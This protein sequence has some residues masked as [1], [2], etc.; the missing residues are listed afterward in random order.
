MFCEF[1]GRFEKC[2]LT[3]SSACVCATVRL[4]LS[5]RF[6]HESDV[7]YAISGVALW[8]VGEITAGFLVL[9]VPWIPKA[10][11]SIPFL[12]HWI[13]VR[14][15]QAS[16]KKSLPRWYKTE[17]PKASR[18]NQD[19]SILNDEMPIDL[20]VLENKSVDNIYGEGVIR[21]EH[22]IEQES[23]ERVPTSLVDS[24]AY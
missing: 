23:V 10:L 18:R 6:L 20:K 5:V 8:I 1:I 15:S 3:G 14:K 16:S 17:T 19:W 7:S 2:R 11:K 4:V 9:G 21:V 22:T 24:K 13:E 12:Q